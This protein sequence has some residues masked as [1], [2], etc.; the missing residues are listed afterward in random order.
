MKQTRPK[1]NVLPS[2]ALLSFHVEGVFF[3]RRSKMSRD[4]ILLGEIDS[5]H[6]VSYPEGELKCQK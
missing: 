3:F 1:Q 5:Y 4:C 6:S 2:V